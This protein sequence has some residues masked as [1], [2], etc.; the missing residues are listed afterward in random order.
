MKLEELRGFKNLKAEEYSGKH[1]WITNKVCLPRRWEVKQPLSHPLKNLFS[2]QTLSWERQSRARSE[3]FSIDNIRELERHENDA[4]SDDGRVNHF[5]M[6]KPSL[7]AWS[8]ERQTSTFLKPWKVIAINDP[9]LTYIEKPTQLHLCSNYTK[10]SKSFSLPLCS[11]CTESNAQSIVNEFLSKLFHFVSSLDRSSKCKEQLTHQ[12]SFL[13]AVHEQT[14]N[15]NWISQVFLHNPHC[16]SFNYSR[17]LHN[18]GK[19]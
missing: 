17:A 18:R 1:C 13:L 3:N 4:K 5:K 8:V 14:W 15:Y 11:S 7:I 6:L 19:F 9:W 2:S 16:S 12:N 10:N